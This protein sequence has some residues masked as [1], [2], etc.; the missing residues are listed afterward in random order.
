MSAM[1]VAW[2]PFAAMQVASAQQDPA[3]AGSV[4]HGRVVGG[5]H[6]GVHRAEL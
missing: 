5:I 2:Y 1:V 4:V 3:A 6:E